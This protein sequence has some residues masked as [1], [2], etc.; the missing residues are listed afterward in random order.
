MALKKIAI[1]EDD[2]LLRQQIALSLSK[3]YEV[4]EAG[5]RNQGEQLLIQEKPALALIDLNL[6][7]SGRSQEGIELIEKIKQELPQTV[8]IVMSG[9]T[10]IDETLKAVEAGAHD[11]F[12]KPFDLTELKLIIQRSLE[13]QQMRQDNT[14]LR[15]ELQKKYS[16][17][18]IIGNSPPM[19]RVFESIRRVADTSATVIIRG[20]SGTG[21]ELIA[22]AIHY[23]SRRHDKPFVS[24]NC[25]ALP[26]TLVETELFG[27]ERGAFTGA[28]AAHTGRF[29]LAHEGTLFLDEIGSVSPMIQAKLLRVLQEKTFE[30]VGGTKKITTDARL[31]TATNENLEQKVSRGEFREDLYYR[32]HVFPVEVPPLRDR[33]EDIPLLLYHFLRNFCR[34]NQIPLKKFHPAALEE[35]MS[36]SW[37][38]NV[39]ELENL[40]QTL[41]LTSDEEIIGLQHLPASVRGYQSASLSLLGGI[42]DGG[43]SLDESVEQFERELIRTALDKAKGVKSKAAEMLALDKNRM[44]YLC[45]K[46]KF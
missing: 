26:E 10:N 3:Q 36:Y 16:F 2:R 33:K 14:R 32:I 31:I 28:V 30:R 13:M 27:H 4:V 7:P 21:K 12:K 41:I 29:E 11:Y 17:D 23:N 18:N 43:I 45:R 6:P 34:E 38:G 5:D 46:Y 19:I 40:V 8:V 25:A 9:N 37:K 35:L 24:V 42:P 20:E 15:Q 22:R 39:R 1:I 44:K